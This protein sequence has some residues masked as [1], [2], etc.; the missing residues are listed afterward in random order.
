MMVPML[1]ENGL[2]QNSS[3]LPRCI[4][5]MCKPSEVKEMSKLISLKDAK[6]YIIR[7]YNHVKCKNIAK[8]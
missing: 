4:S 6:H 1:F 2:V 5:Y 8:K 3:F 7:A